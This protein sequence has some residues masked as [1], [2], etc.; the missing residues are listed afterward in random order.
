MGQS[1]CQSQHLI[2]ELFWML[3]DK[4]KQKRLGSNKLW[5]YKSESVDK[6]V[7]GLGANCCCVLVDQVITAA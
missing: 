7:V 5:P 2:T 6:K 1:L 4:E 3:Q